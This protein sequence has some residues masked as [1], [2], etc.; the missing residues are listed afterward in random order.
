MKQSWHIVN[1]QTS[2]VIFNTHNSKMAKDA[3][4]F[5]IDVKMDD[6]FKIETLQPFRYIRLSYLRKMDTCELTDYFNS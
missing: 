5:L 3:C 2:K 6:Y 1:K 4:Q